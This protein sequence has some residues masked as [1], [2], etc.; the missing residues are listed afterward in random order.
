MTVLAKCT[1]RPQ[2]TLTLKWAKVPNLDVTNTHKSQISLVSLYDYLFPRYQQ[3]LI[4]ALA[5]I[6]FNLFLKKKLYI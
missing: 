5:T 6:N 3:R 2:M 1:E 4:F